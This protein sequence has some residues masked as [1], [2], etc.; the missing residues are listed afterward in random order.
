MN[1]THRII[2]NVVVIACGSDPGSESEWQAFLDDVER[3]R[4][5]RLLLFSAGG[6]LDARQRAALGVLMQTGD[7]KAVVLTDS[8]E[9]KNV[10][11]ALALFGRGWKTFDPIDL[12]E[13]LKFLGAAQSHRIIEAV[14][15]MRSKVSA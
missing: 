9:M 5:N 14:A 11:A 13:A 10:A 15:A 12:S 3:R 2:G 8:A 6:T 7:W 1:L 4:V